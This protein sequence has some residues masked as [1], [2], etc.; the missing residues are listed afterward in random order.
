T[1]IPDTNQAPVITDA[2]ITNV[3]K[4][5]Y[6][7]TCK[8]TDDSQVTSVLMPT[9][10]ENGGQDDLIWYETT[11]NAERYTINVKTSDH[12][13]DTGKYNTHIYEY[14]AEGK[15]TVVRLETEVPENQAP[16]ITD[17]YVTNIT[18]QGYTV[19]C[20][21]VDDGNIDRVQMLTWS[22]NGGQDDLIWYE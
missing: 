20:E 5:G 4:D 3:S 18:R 6:T 2:K 13:N 19:T 10:S 9:W 7:V 14:D 17:A 11:K 8:V 22:E 15:T 21:V 12:N 1:E 16:K